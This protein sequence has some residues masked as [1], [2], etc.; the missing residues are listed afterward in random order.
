MNW[1]VSNGIGGSCERDYATGDQ[2]AV[3][4]IAHRAVMI[5]GFPPRPH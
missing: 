3:S 1:D 5:G 2:V 4:A